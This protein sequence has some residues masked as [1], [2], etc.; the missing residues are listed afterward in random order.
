[1][2]DNTNLKLRDLRDICVQEF[3]AFSHGEAYLHIMNQRIN[4]RG[5]YLLDE[6]EAA[7]SAAKQ[8]TLIHFMRN[9]LSQFNSQFIIA[10]LSPILIAYLNSNIYEITENGMEKTK[11]NDTEHYTVTKSF[12]N[13]PAA[14]LRHL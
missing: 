13:N 8:L 2:K 14:F 1:M 11:L 10:T 3:Q 7:L 6:P 5:V 9:H 12:I 4:K